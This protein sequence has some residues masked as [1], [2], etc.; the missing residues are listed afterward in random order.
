MS[1]LT[2]DS[3]A[4]DQAAAVR[5][6]EISAA[7]LLELHLDRIE[8]RNPELNGMIGLLGAKIWV[9][10]QVNFGNPVNLVPIAAGLTMGIGLADN[11]FFNIT[12]DFP[13]GGIAM[14][15]LIIV[16]GYHLARVVARA[17]GRDD[18]GTMLAVGD[19]GAH[20]TDGEAQ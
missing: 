3:T 17:A 6:G 14:G 4:R 11:A 8:E 10:N 1:D 18:D 20:K 13:L 16:L 15:T 19:R 9:E 12:A 2:V 5:S 7:E